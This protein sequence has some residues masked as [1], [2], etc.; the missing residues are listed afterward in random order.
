[1]DNAVVF[2]TH[3]STTHHSTTHHSTTHLFGDLADSGAKV[4]RKPFRLEPTFDQDGR[5]R[6]QHARQDVLGDF[7]H[8][9]FPAALVHGIEHDETDE[10]GSNEVDFRV[11]LNPSQ[12]QDSFGVG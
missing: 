5:F 3:H 11:R 7:Y 2:T 4:K 10:A 1:M 12:L 8:V 6:V 9:E